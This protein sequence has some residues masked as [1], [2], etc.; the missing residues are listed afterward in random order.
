MRGLVINV[1]PATGSVSSRGGN[2]IEG[3]YI[4][5][6]V[7]GNAVQGNGANGVQVIDSPGNTIGGTTPAARNLIAGNVGEEVRLDGAATTGNMIRG[8]FIGTNASGSAV[9]SNSNSGVF[10]RKAPGN[11][12]IGN[13]VSGNNGFAGIAICG[14]RRPAAAVQPARRPATRPETSCR[15]TS[16]AP[17]PPGAAPLGNSGYGVSIDSSAQRADR[18]HAGRGQRDRVQRPDDVRSREWWSSDREPRGIRSCAT[19]STPM[20]GWVSTLPRRR[21]PERWQR[22]T[23]RCP[24]TTKMPGRTAFRTSRC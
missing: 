2:L 6:D 21:D 19:A 4:G 20:E 16:S 24:R 8:N 15:V 3:N 17:T 11:S 5:T 12:V 13:V 14:F 23:R 7:T 9:L 1:S 22:R 10:I 18:R